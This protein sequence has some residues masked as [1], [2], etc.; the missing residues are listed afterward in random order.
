M[1]YR[2]EK[3]NVL[4]VSVSGGDGQVAV[5]KLS[6]FLRKMC[7]Y[8]RRDEQQLI[9][10]TRV[11]SR[12]LRTPKFFGVENKLTTAVCGPNI[13]FTRKDVLGIIRR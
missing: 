13:S 10:F 2:E 4:N 6:N 12:V 1:S 5:V 11:R 3:L 9:V 7:Q 8:T